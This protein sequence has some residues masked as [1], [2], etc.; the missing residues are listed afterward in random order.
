MKVN[1]I[2]C[3]VVRWFGL[4]RFFIIPNLFVC[5]GRVELDLA[6]FTKSN[7]LWEVEIKISKADTIKDKQ[8]AK[9]TNSSIS[10]NYKRSVKRTWYAFPENLRDCSD[11]VHEEAGILIVNDKGKVN[12]IRKPVDNKAARRFD[13]D[14]ILHYTSMLHFRYW[15]EHWRAWWLSRLEKPIDI[16]EHKVYK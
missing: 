16:D 12:E 10:L 8:K 3:A 7:Y 6:L 15:N 14:E 11:L 9:F 1:D 4:E 13:N 2:E 5:G